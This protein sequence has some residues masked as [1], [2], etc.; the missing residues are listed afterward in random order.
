MLKGLRVGYEPVNKE[1]DFTS[2]AE[3]GSMGTIEGVQHRLS[4]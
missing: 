3:W 4:I 2:Y 1:N